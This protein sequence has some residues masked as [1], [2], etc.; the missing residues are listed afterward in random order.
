MTLLLGSFPYFPVDT[1]SSEQVIFV[2]LTISGAA[3]V[4]KEQKTQ[5][6][7]KSRHKTR[8]MKKV[9]PTAKLSSFLEF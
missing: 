9:F 4:A 8:F 1:E 5:Q 6:V 7:D 3:L 2:L